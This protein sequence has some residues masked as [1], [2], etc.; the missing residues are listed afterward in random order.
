MTDLAGELTEVVRAHGRRRRRAE[1][2][3]LGLRLAGP[4]AVLAALL[5]VGVQLELVS[6]T[7]A[8]VIA[9]LASLAVSIAVLVG[10]F[11]PVDDVA[12][13]KRLDDALGLKDRLA[14]ALSF[15][16]HAECTAFERAAIL[17]A[18]RFLP[19]VTSR[20]AVGVALRPSVTRLAVAAVVGGLLVLGVHVVRGLPDDAREEARPVDTA[21]RD[22][23][24]RDDGKKTETSTPETPD[25]ALVAVEDTT[26]TEE[27]AT[28]AFSE[29]EREAM[30]ALG[31]AETSQADR[32]LQQAAYLDETELDDSGLG[33]DG[34][35]GDE[36]RV[37]MTE[38]DI[39]MIRE[40]V[41]EAQE[42]RK[43]GRDQDRSDDDINLEVLIK[44]HGDASKRPPDSDANRQRSSGGATGPSQDTRIKPRR[45][46]VDA[47]VEFKI[48]SMRSLTP[49][50]D[51]G[52]TRIVL[53]EAIMRTSGVP[54]PPLVDARTV[55]TTSPVVA[56]TP[57]V[58]QDV[59][60]G[61]R[62][63]VSKYFEGLRQLK[64]SP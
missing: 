14:S 39:D 55:T 10:T 18:E 13:A 33:R 8:L 19:D 26:L 22:V 15:L 62:A 11:R 21:G 34:T 29:A 38:P 50:G 28:S 63:V 49:P 1:V 46:P 60:P 32:L 37:T 7:S 16:K 64:K 56:P 4:A 25:D 9:L 24:T 41:K 59:P 43:E 47:R 48:I 54:Q 58:T 23:G 61:L 36:D 17:D 52:A 6:W 3:T 42:R 51:S 53:S 57:V 20:G 5:V 35:S 40:M 30:A 45:V 27:T 31:A 2:G 44:A 12:E